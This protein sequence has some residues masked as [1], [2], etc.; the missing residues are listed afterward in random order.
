MKAGRSRRRRAAEQDAEETTSLTV[1]SERAI[2]V[3]ME[4]RNKRSQ[5]SLEETLS[6]LS[7]LTQ[8]AGAEV[9]GQITQRSDRFAQTYVG[10]GKVE[11]INELVAQEEAQVVIFDDELTPTQQ[12]NLE[13]ALS[14]K[15]IDRTALILDVFGRHARTYEGKLQVE[16]AQHQYLLPRLVGQWSH[17]ERLGGGIGTRGPG[18]TQLETDRRLIRNRIQKITKELEGVRKRRSLYMGRRKSA[19]IPIV[20]LVGYTNAGKSTLFNTLSPSDGKNKVE[21]ADQLF[22]TLD[23]VTRRIRLPSGGPLLLTDTVGFIQKL[24]PTVVAAFRATLEE[25]SE[26]DLLL[27]VVDVTHPKS[28]EQAG[29]VETTLKELGLE[30]KPRLLVLNKMDL[31]PEGSDGAASPT[32]LG[33]QHQTK[34]FISAAKGWNMDSLL[35]EI[36]VQLMSIDKPLLSVSGPANY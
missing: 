33:R 17:L 36:E 2:L 27:H 12:R 7:Y 19:S 35:Q 8:A 6:E 32:S 14:V 1:E 15:V 21:A 25:L 3:A 4:L 22:S 10:K 30:E 26:S 23:P 24:S 9:A 29:V 28:A 13:A 5:W 11:E 18:E 20:S 34:V 16:L 31:L